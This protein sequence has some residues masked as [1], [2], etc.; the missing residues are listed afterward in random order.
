MVPESHF[1]RVLH[2]N[3][4][5]SAK[6]LN[7][8][9]CL[10]VEP[11]ER[12]KQLNEDIDRLQAERDELQCFVDSHRA[13]AAPFRR[14]PADIW[15]EIFAHCLPTNK[16]NL[17]SC[18]LKEAPLLLTTVCRAWR[19][20]ALNTPRLW[21]SVHIFFSNPPMSTEHE[22]FLSEMR[23]RTLQGIKL[24][25]DRSK[26]R[27]LTLSIYMADDVS[28]PSLSA[29]ENA[30]FSDLMNLL[31]K[32]SR[33]WKSLSLGHGVGALHQQPLQQLTR[34]DVPLLETVHIGA[35]AILF[36]SS[37]GVTPQVT[38][39][40]PSPL[41]NLLCEL[42]SLRSLQLNQGSMSSFCIPL[43]WSRLT[44]LSLSFLCPALPNSTSSSIDLLQRI[45][46]TCRSLTVLTFYS[47]L[48]SGAPLGDPVECTSLRDLRLIL[49]GSLCDFSNHDQ[50][51]HFTGPFPFHSHVKDIYRCIRTPQLRRLTLQMGSN[52]SRG[53]AADVDLPFRT[54]IEGSPHLTHLQLVGYHILGAEAL[55]HCLQ[56]A[57]SL[58]TLKLQP[59][60]LPTR[61]RRSSRRRYVEQVVAPNDG[62]VPKLLSSLNELG[63]CPQLEVF[64]CGRCSPDD[65]TSLLGFLQD[66]N[67]MSRMKRFR[68]GMGGLHVQQV[69]TMTSPTLLEAF[70]SLRESHGMSVDLEWKEV[71]PLPDRRWKNDPYRGLPVASSW[72]ATVRKW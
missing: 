65:V 27:P 53:T 20:I 34:D 66:E 59:E 43:G 38:E 6:E 2:T 30:R 56:S 58:T 71:E 50:G 51:P 31:V 37:T 26:S 42:T 48:P 29:E 35:N 41:S 25:L 69:N 63:S 61:K 72:E 52:H 17:S 15:G 10:V 32:Y 49:K 14:F 1:T 47:Y 22:S 40:R 3:Y 24:W 70:T 8:I 67:R 18:T 55:S 23:A 7:E 13:L 62:W 57:P 9:Q 11:T 16:L 60:H 44:D 28:P 4:I 21:G 45:A 36:H 5:P 54:L 12:I 19:E 39:L 33:R 68:A 46:Q 64:D